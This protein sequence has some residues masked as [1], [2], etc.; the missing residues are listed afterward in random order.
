MLGDELNLTRLPKHALHCGQVCHPPLEVTK[1]DPTS[2][3]GEDVMNK[4]LMNFSADLRRISYW[5]YDGRFTLASQMLKRC[6]VMYRDI[7]KSVGCYDDIWEA[8]DNVEKLIGG[9]EK[10]SERALTASNIFLNHSLLAK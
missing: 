4:P 7:N 3:G 6:R 5:I 1:G 9:K 2:R 8:I 10:A